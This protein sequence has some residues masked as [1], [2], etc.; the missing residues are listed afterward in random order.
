MLLGETCS[1][2]PGWTLKNMHIFKNQKSE[3]PLVVNECLAHLECFKQKTLK[4][5]S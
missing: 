4:I 5:F 3:N 2:G 1:Q